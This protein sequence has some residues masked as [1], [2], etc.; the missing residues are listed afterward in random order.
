VKKGLDRLKR[1]LYL[2]SQKDDPVAYAKLMKQRAADAKA[3]KQAEAERALAEAQRLREA[4][5]Q[6]RREQEAYEQQAWQRLRSEARQ[7]VD[8]MYKPQP[9]DEQGRVTARDE[10][11]KAMRKARLERGTPSMVELETAVGRGYLIYRNGQWI[12]VYWRHR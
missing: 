10:M 11:R 4:R 8:E 12:T 2:A 6:S 7:Y 5:E 1:K 9:R 3:R